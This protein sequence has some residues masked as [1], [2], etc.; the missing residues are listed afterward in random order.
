MIEV[1]QRRAIG[2]QDRIQLS[3][4]EIDV[5]MI[6]WRRC[7]DAIK[8]PGANT[9]FDRSI[10]IAIFWIRIRID[11]QLVLLSQG[12]DR[13]AHTNAKIVRFVFSLALGPV[14]CRRM[15]RFE[16]VPV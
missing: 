6:V 12:F 11:S 10:V 14:G 15:S 1:E 16:I 7:S 2:T 13:P 9:N 5:R 3:H 4:I 8:L